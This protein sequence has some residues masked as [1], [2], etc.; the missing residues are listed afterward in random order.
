M[1]SIY[2]NASEHWL[3]NAYEWKNWNDVCGLSLNILDFCSII[4][5]YLLDRWK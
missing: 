4:I 5:N 2:E 3:V 1:K